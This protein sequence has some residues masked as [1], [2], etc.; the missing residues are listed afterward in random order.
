MFIFIVLTVVWKLFENDNNSAEVLFWVYFSRREN[1]NNTL[2]YARGRVFGDVLRGDKFV[3]VCFLPE[4]FWGEITLSEMF[5]FFL[6]ETLRHR[7]PDRTVLLRAR[8][9]GR[10]GFYVFS[11]FCAVNTVFSASRGNTHASLRPRVGFL[12]R[13]VC[14]PHPVRSGSGRWRGFSRRGQECNRT[15]RVT[16]KYLWS[17][18]PAGKQPVHV[19]VCALRRRS[20][21]IIAKNIQH[22]DRSASNFI[23]QTWIN[24][25]WV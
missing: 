18:V 5:F 8:T 2:Q 24:S 13:G 11:V 6:P 19:I 21:N 1:S 17:R 12:R 7:S 22:F 23:R 4:T 9:D 10:R 20:R 14:N 16:Y 3:G 15:T 25:Q